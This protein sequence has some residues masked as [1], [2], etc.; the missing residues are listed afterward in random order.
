MGVG[1]EIIDIAL[2]I[3]TWLEISYSLNRLCN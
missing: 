2:Y 1:H 3:Y